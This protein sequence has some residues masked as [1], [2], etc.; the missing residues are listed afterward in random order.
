MAR[1]FL[2][3]I[4]AESHVVQTTRAAVP[5]RTSQTDV[6]SHLL[7]I[8]HMRIS[9]LVFD[10]CCG[11]ANLSVRLVESCR[12]W[13]RVPDAGLADQGTSPIHICVASER[14]LIDRSSVEE[15]RSRQPS[16]I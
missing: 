15:L 9:P 4:N 5:M 10:A 2:V 16:R 14:L 6:R 7:V 1:L 13:S 8:E 3:G 12:L 11:C